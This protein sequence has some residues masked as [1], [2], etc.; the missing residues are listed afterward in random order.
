MKD[1]KVN[2][3]NWDELDLSTKI[4]AITFVLS[5]ILIPLMA[6]Y[7]LMANCSTLIK[8][9]AVIVGIHFFSRIKFTRKY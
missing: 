5:I 2:E 3:T 9:I 4:K 8:V 6:V 7:I 1:L